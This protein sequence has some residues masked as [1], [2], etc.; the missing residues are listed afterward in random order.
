MEEIDQ[1]VKKFDKARKFYD[2][3]P[4]EV[5][6]HTQA[7]IKKEDLDGYWDREAEPTTPS[8]NDED[9]SAD[10]HPN[11]FTNLALRL[12][13]PHGVVGAPVGRPADWWHDGNA[14][15]SEKVDTF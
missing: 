15:A 5:T 9:S 11:G 8:F 2:K 6:H 12:D 3:N 13:A 7:V 4:Y 1:M 10:K 14:G